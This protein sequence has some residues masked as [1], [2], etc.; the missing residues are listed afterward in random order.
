[1]VHIG[2]QTSNYF[3]VLTI[4][5]RLP[6]SVS[7]LEYG[8][9]VVFLLS[10]GTRRMVIQLYYTVTIHTLYTVCYAPY[11][12]QANLFVL[13]QVTLYGVTSE[14]FS[15]IRSRYSRYFQQTGYA[16]TETGLNVGSNAFQLVLHQCCKTSK[17]NV[18]LA[19]YK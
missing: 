13:K 7:A 12:P 19:Y 3:T 15:P 9:R 5:L 10:F 18:F 14:L 17:L 4:T 11:Q 1:M 6:F 16:A 2:E 8:V